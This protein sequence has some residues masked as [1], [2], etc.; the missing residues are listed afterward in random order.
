MSKLER[1]LILIEMAK[2]GYK[3]LP[4]DCVLVAVVLLCGNG[5][6]TGGLCQVGRMTWLSWL[7]AS[8]ESWRTYWPDRTDGRKAALML[9]LAHIKILDKG[10][11]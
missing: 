11:G 2:R 4:E 1:V 9:P 3:Q 10:A 8:L 5:S 6:L 7:E